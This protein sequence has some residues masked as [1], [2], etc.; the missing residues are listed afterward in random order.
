MH[1]LRVLIRIASTLVKAIPIN[2]R[3]ICFDKELDKY[4]GAA[5]G[6]TLVKAIPINSHNI[7]FYKELDKYTRAVI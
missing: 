1:M 5:I 3:N 7:C 2:I 6:R 4:T